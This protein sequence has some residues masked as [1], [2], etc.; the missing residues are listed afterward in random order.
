MLAPPEEPLEPLAERT[1][2]DGGSEQVED[3]KGSSQVPFSET[4]WNSVCL[5]WRATGS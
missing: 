1:Q 3:C 4:A 5:T 2:P